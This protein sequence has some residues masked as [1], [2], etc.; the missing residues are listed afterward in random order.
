MVVDLEGSGEVKFFFQGRL[1]TDRVGSRSKNLSLYK[2]K[3]YKIRAQK[4]IVDCRARAGYF[5]FCFE[6][7][8]VPE[9]NATNDA[10]DMKD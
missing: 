5:D 1:F 6:N 2:I 7:K 10:T 9:S 8:E 3:A 4:R